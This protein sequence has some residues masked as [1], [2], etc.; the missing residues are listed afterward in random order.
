VD[1]A[2]GAAV[3]RAVDLVHGSMVDQGQGDIPRSNLRRRFRIGRLWMRARDQAAVDASGPLA[4][5]LMAAGDGRR[6]SGGGGCAGDGGTRRSRRRTSSALLETELE[7][8]V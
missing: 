3:D 7:I 2:A 8:S 6:A 5:D 1:R 4:V